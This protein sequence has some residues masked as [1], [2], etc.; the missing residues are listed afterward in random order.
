MLDQGAKWC[1]LDKQIFEK[2]FKIKREITKINKWRAP[3]KN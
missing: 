2:K 1:N 3:I